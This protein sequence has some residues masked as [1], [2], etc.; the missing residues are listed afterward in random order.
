[1]VI[2]RSVLG[3]NEAFESLK[4]P[5][6]T[7]LSD[8]GYAMGGAGYQE[9]T[10]IGYVTNE[11]TNVSYSEQSVG[12]FIS[13]I[14]GI[15]LE[16]YS[17]LN[18]PPS[19]GN[20]SVYQAQPYLN[21][22][23][24]IR[25]K[26]KMAWVGGF[27]SLY[28]INP[29]T[30]LSEEQTCT[31]EYRLVSPDETET[32]GSDSMSV[33]FSWMDAS[34]FFA[35]SNLDVVI[36]YGPLLAMVPAGSDFKFQYKIDG[37]KQMVGYTVE[38]GEEIEGSLTC[39][40]WPNY[41]TVIDEK[42][43]GQVGSTDSIILDGI[44]YMLEI[45]DEQ[46]VWF[47]AYFRGMPGPQALTL[48]LKVNLTNYLNVYAG[49]I[50][51][52]E[53]I[54]GYTGPNDSL[55]FGP[56]ETTTNLSI[57]AVNNTTG[58]ITTVLLQY[59]NPENGL[60]IQSTTYPLQWAHLDEFNM[61]NSQR[62]NKEE[63]IVLQIMF[64]S[65]DYNE[66]DYIYFEAFTDAITPRKI[67]KNNTEGNNPLIDTST[68]VLHE[69]FTNEV[70]PTFIWDSNYSVYEIGDVEITSGDEVITVED[71]WTY[72][73]HAIHIEGVEPISSQWSSVI[74]PSITP[75]V[76]NA[77]VNIREASFEEFTLT[78]VSHSVEEQPALENNFFEFKYNFE[79]VKTATDQVIWGWSRDVQLNS[80]TDENEE[81]SF[82]LSGAF[83]S[84]SINLFGDDFL[85]SQL[86]DGDELKIR[87][88]PEPYRK[89][90]N[91][92]EGYIRL[93][94]TFINTHWYNNSYISYDST[95]PVE[96]DYWLHGDFVIK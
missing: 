8:Y 37:L 86:V 83:M 10:W 31:L 14:P 65:F 93:T 24:K 3:A 55:T 63:T 60:W 79:L 50:A 30:G 19:W 51:G 72:S 58:D 64:S 52:A 90:D 54:Q 49:Q 46:G 32:Y 87:V 77:G 70:Q 38:E 43:I 42:T 73:M 96:A 4:M 25:L 82:E 92:K 95:I 27:S 61:G 33:T 35:M 76:G 80:T 15:D 18:D 23:C 16:P 85:A 69:G 68:L 22:N 71:T 5:N 91:T 57:R 12:E 29:E 89:W 48:S 2:P 94:G 41:E 34:Q 53:S 67:S 26:G 13:A 28:N 44:M 47:S 45:E 74:Y 7:Y 40:W 88:K 56:E 17:F 62:W 81:V 36:D 20:V 6:V 66:G 21:S 9:M 1:M 75:S 39:M 78:A 84:E 59:V 11:I